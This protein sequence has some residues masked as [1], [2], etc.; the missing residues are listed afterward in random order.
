MFARRMIVAAC[1]AGAALMLW[2]AAAAAKVTV[3]K[4]GN[5]AF[6]ITFNL[7]FSGPGATE[8]FATKVKNEIVNCWKGHKVGCCPVNIVVNTKVGGAAAAGY[9]QINVADDSAGGVDDHVSCTTTGT[10]NG[11]DTKGNWDNN[12]P[13]QTYAHEAGHLAGLGDTYKTEGAIKQVNGK[14]VDCRKTTPCAG[15]GMDKMAQLGGMITQDAIE[16]LIKKAGLDCPK[17]CWPTSTPGQNT[18]GGGQ[19]SVPGPQKRPTEGKTQYDFNVPFSGG[20]MQFHQA[21]DVGGAI[22]PVQILGGGFRMMTDTIPPPYL[23]PLWDPQLASF[24]LTNLMFQFP[25]FQWTPSQTTGPT[26]MT[27]TNVLPEAESVG[28]I[29]AFTGNFHGVI[30]GQLINSIPGPGESPA[31][32]GNPYLFLGSWNGFLDYSNGAVYFSMDLMPLAHAPVADVGPA[33]AADRRLKLISSGPD[34]VRLR[35]SLPARTPVRLIVTDASGRTVR[36]LESGERE[37]GDHDLQWDRRG[38][39]GASLPP[40]VYFV[41]LRAGRWSGA[42]KL[43]ILR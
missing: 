9:D 5:C 30:Q 7:Q 8:A 14:S 10:V 28:M 36:T 27:L 19:S 35:Y 17:E 40:G 32:P 12:E 29:D 31:S 15:H 11:G 39:S 24:Q 18:T 2:A 43:A 21:P 13:A 26:Q 3:E 20:T 33:A 16:S 4:D 25:S 38:S 1:L 42:I 34:G 6:K 22:V 41:S 37:A 23:N